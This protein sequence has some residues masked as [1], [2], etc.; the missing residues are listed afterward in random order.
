MDS[1][2]VPN[3][4]LNKNGL[5]IITH[6]IF[7]ELKAKRSIFSKQLEAIFQEANGDLELKIT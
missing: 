6:N 2:E 5:K 1:L 7:S 3:H 4:E